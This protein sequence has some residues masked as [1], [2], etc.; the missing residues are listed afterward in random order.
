MYNMDSKC[1]WEYK[2]NKMGQRADWV[3]E[4]AAVPPAAVVVMASWQNTFSCLLDL[5]FDLYA[6]SLIPK[7]SN[8]DLTENLVSELTLIRV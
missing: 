2:V 6:N 1:V 4:I 8:L 7:A 5:I 3:K